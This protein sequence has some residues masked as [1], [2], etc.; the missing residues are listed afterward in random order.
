MRWHDSTKE[1]PSRW[2]MFWVLC[3]GYLLSVVGWFVKA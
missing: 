3:L 1:F 2:A